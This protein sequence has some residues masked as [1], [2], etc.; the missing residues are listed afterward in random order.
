MTVE[1]TKDELVFVTE[2][3]TRIEGGEVLIS[4]DILD[5]EEWTVTMAF[6]VW[7][8]DEVPAGT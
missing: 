6:R 7:Q 3:Y 2:E 8:G 4:S 5:S 1:I